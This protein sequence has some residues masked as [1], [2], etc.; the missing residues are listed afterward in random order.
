MQRDCFYSLNLAFC[1]AFVAVAV[2]VLKFLIEHT[3]PRAM[4]EHIVCRPDTKVPE[5]SS[6]NDWPT[7]RGSTE[8]RFKTFEIPWPMTLKEQ[9]CLFFD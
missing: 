4:K 5:K 8:Q 3:R 6:N 2:V 7:F 1:G 9:F